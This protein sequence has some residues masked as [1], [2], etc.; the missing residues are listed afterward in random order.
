MTVSIRKVWRSRAMTS[1]YQ[2]TAARGSGRIAALAAFVSAY[3]KNHLTGRGVAREFAEDQQALARN[4]AIAYIDPAGAV[5]KFK[6]QATTDASGALLRLL[7]S[8]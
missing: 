2:A 7:A 4:I 1:W 6:R 5:E 8:R 3:Y